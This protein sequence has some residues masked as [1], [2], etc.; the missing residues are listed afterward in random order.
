[1]GI[2]I[3]DVQGPAWLKSPGFGSG[4]SNTQAKP[5][6]TALAWLRPGPGLSHGFCELCNMNGAKLYTKIIWKDR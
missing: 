5:W 4:F 3:S 6:L 2:T 1:M